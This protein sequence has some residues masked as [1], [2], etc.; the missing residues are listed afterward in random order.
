MRGEKNVRIHQQ[1]MAPPKIKTHQ[2]EVSEGESE[3][4]GILCK[5][6]ALGPEAYLIAGGRAQTE[7]KC[8]ELVVGECGFPVHG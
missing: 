1:K 4:L 3:V 2:A 7:S 5:C 6:N 8:P